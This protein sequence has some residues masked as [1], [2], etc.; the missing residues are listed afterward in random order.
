MAP[1][2]EANNLG[3]FFNLLDSNGMLSVLIRITDEV[4]LMSTHNIQFHDKI[5]KF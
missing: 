3:I 4:I 2:Q 1:G 5:R